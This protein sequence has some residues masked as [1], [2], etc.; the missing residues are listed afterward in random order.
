MQD[1]DTGQGVEKVENVADVIAN[2]RERLFNPPS[3]GWRP[4]PERYIKGEQG[5]HVHLKQRGFSLSDSLES[6]P[7]D[8]CATFEWPRGVLLVNFELDFWRARIREH[9]HDSAKVEQVAGQDQV[10]VLVDIPE[11]IQNR[12]RLLGRILPVFKRLQLLEVCAKTWPDS[13]EALQVF[14]LG[15]RDESFAMVPGAGV[16]MDRESNVSPFATQTLW[17]DR[18]GGGLG[19]W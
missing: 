19:W 7:P 13:P 6:G 8:L 4:L 3:M 16:D 15:P 18:V 11:F 10:A 1:R 9:E 17:R 5:V 2:L 12:Q 14:G